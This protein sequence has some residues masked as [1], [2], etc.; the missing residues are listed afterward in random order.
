MLFRSE[1]GYEDGFSAA[2]NSSSAIIGPIFPPSIPM[3][4]ISVISGISLGR[5]FLGGIVPGILVAIFLAVAVTW[6]CR[7]KD[8]RTV[9]SEMRISRLA[10]L[11]KDSILAL[12]GPLII[13]FGIVSGTITLVEVAILAVFYFILISMFAYRSIKVRELFTVFKEAAVF[14]S[15]IM[16]IFAAV[17]VFQYIVATAQLGDRLMQLIIELQLG[18]GSFLFFSMV[19][20]LLMGCI[21]DAVPVM[22]IF[23]P[24]LLP[25][26][27][28]LGVDPTHYG[29][30][31]VFNLMIGLLTPPIGGLLFIQTKISGLP[32]KDLVK[33]V[34]PHTVVLL[35]LLAIITYTPALVTFVPDLLLGGS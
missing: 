35:I 14:S 25:I 17:G 3:I 19:F 9:K 8:Y 15:S 13:L 26:A 22:L 27:T 20:F 32:F 24:V 34:W 11:L 29:V 18:R 10:S 6:H 4:F 12:I 28:N 16:I 5:L 33:A 21:M 30:I 31:V 23:F 2:I 1:R 7:K